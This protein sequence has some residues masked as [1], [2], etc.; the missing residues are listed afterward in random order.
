MTRS[1][2][3]EEAGEE[4]WADCREDTA[5]DGIVTRRQGLGYH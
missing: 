5:Q 2:R 4:L 3:E 1:E